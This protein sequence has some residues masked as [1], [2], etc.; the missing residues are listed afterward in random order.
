MEPG[1]GAP[2]AGKHTSDGKAIIAQPATERK[3]RPAAGGQGQDDTYCRGI[4]QEYDT[5]TDVEQIRVDHPE[6]IFL[7]DDEI[8]TILEQAEVIRHR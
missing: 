7:D 3:S 5:T 2:P 4:A 1:R 8:E 6:L